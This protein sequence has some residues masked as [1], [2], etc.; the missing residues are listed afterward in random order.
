MYLC[1]YDIQI[2]RYQQ[3]YKRMKRMSICKIMTAAILLAGGCGTAA[4][5]DIA[6]VDARTAATQ[7]VEKKNKVVQA[8]VVEKQNKV[9]QAKVVQAKVVEKQNKVKQA[10]VVQAKVVEK[11]NKVKQNKVKQNKVKQNKV[12]K[13]QTAQDGQTVELNPDKMPEFPGGNNGLAEWLSKNTK[14]PKEAKDNN[15]QGRV[16]VSFVVD[17]D[18]KATDAKVV[19]SI[20]PTIDKEAMRLIEVMPRWTPGKKDGL[21]VAVRFTLPMTFKL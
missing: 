19:R 9:K 12:V 7:V 14:Y 6:T 4:A 13:Q 17:K 21:P 10:K 18:G 11:Q 16:V 20:S 1:H 5:Q 8:K 2:K 3:R 15:E